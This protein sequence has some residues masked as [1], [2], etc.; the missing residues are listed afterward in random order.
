MIP[1]IRRGR[2]LPRSSA[3]VVP[4]AACD[5][6]RGRRRRC[7]LRQNFFRLYRN[8]IL[9]E[10]TRLKALA[11]IYTMHSFAQLLLELCNLFFVKNLLKC[12]LHFGKFSKR[13]KKNAF[14]S[15]RRDLHNALLCA[16]QKISMFCQKNC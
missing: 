3:Q 12:L 2:F 16:A 8:E 10:N 4:R 11:E 13:S 14:E 6:D 5:A 15:S 7:W 1:H 9:Q